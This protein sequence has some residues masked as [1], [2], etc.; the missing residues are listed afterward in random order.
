MD[1][2]EYTD[3]IMMFNK[4]TGKFEDI[5]KL[6]LRRGDHSVSVVNVNDYKCI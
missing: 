2:K 1:S 4:E 3:K 6:K 5:G